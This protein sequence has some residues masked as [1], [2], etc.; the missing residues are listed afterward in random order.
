MRGLV[1]ST[2]TILLFSLLLATA[3]FQAASFQNAGLTVAKKVVFT[4]DDVQEDLLHLTG[5]NVVKDETNLSIGDVI[6]PT[7]P[8][9]TS[10]QAYNTFIQDYYK[11]KNYEVAILDADGTPITNFD[12]FGKVSCPGKVVFTI[13]QFNITYEYPDWSKNQL[14]IVCKSGSSP[15]CNFAYVQNFSLKFNF[16]TINFSCYPS[17]W[18]NCTSSDIDWG[19]YDKVFGPGACTGNEACLLKNYSI[20]LIDGKNKVYYCPGVYGDDSGNTKGVNCPATVFN[21]LDSSI[22]TLVVKASP[23]WIKMEFGDGG[24]FRLK[25]T[26]PNSDS[27]CS[28]AL[29][30]E[31]NMTFNTTDFVIDI[32]AM[33]RVRDLY[34]NFSETRKI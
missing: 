2:L 23:C 17:V 6:P 8:V 13:R 25:G 9:A 31:V 28:F 10:L 12:C 32:P 33:L 5:L 26:Q 15:P 22:A 30:S 20:M 24:R 11:E 1:F 19:Q 14:D 21:W 7:D 4:W 16:S 27:D 34:Y 18:N 3:L 29:S